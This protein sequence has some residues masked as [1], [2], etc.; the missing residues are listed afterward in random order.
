[1]CRNFKKTFDVTKVS[2]LS[3]MFYTFGRLEEKCIFSKGNTQ[4]IARFFFQNFI[5]NSFFQ[6]KNV[7]HN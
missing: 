1:M 5:R 3:R 4:L 2:R 6:T 7:D